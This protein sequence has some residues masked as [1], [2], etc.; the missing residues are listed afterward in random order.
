MTVISLDRFLTD[1]QLIKL[2]EYW[3]FSLSR[4]GVSFYNLALQMVEELLPEINKKLEQENDPRF[5][6]Y[7][8][9]Y[10]FT[11]TYGGSR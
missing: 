3:L 10:V 8:I 11:Q 4:K 2:E 9:E 6:T 7:L 1:E 5:L